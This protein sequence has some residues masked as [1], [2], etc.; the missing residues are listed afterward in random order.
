MLDIDF[1]KF[2]SAWGKAPLRI[3]PYYCLPLR[4]P[5]SRCRLCIE[6][7]PIVRGGAVEKR[8]AAKIECYKVPFD[9]STASSLRLPCLAHITPRLILRI[10]SLGANEIV[11]RDAR[12]E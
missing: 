9:Y 2:F 3:N 12:S 11:I 4:S 1:T 7:C 5:K 6:N 10:L 8:A